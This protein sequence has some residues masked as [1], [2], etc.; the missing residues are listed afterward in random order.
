MI[1]SLKKV[2]YLFVFIAF[3]VQ[4]IFNIASA[5]NKHMDDYTPPPMFG[6]TTDVPSFPKSSETKSSSTLDLIN[7]DSITGHSRNLEPS[8]SAK[9]FKPP[10]PPKR[11]SAFRVSKDYLGR[12]MA[13]ESPSVVLQNRPAPPVISPPELAGDALNAELRAMDAV[14]VYKNIGGNIKADTAFINIP[15]R[16]NHTHPSQ[17]KFQDISLGFD[18]NETALARAHTILIQR[19][20][21]P[22]LYSGELSALTIE[23]DIGKNSEERRQSLARAISVR[24]YLENNGIDRSNI[25]INQSNAGKDLSKENTVVIRSAR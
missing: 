6:D 9:A 3:L 23:I 13:P 17:Q 12:M 15:V 5:Q 7:L 8:P 18:Q 21:L 4:A 20:V 14:D 24:N 11:P 1:H 2:L 25:T 16:K 10:L 19:D 22:F